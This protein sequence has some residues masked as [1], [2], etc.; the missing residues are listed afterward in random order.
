MTFVVSLS[1][2]PTGTVTLSYQ[3][4][5]DTATPPDYFG[6]SGTITF[7]ALQVSKTITIGIVSDNYPERDETLQLRILGSSGPV[8][9][10]DSVGVGTIVSDD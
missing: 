10:T 6:R 9:V 7:S 5:N 3:T 1:K 2:R 4:F 8:T